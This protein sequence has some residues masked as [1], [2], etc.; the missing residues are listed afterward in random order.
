MNLLKR[1]RIFR[2][3]AGYI[4][5]IRQ[6]RYALNESEET[7][8]RIQKN[9][10]YITGKSKNKFI[11]E[12][13]NNEKNMKE[14]YES[15]IDIKNLEIDKLKKEKIESLNLFISIKEKKIEL[16]QLLPFIEEKLILISGFDQN[17]LQQLNILND[18]IKNFINDFNRLEDNSKKKLDKIK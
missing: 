5:E 12:K 4:H 2:E 7:I 15:I 14:N 1:F 9:Y 10:E 8:K 3:N 17:K 16:E 6:L 11:E 18:R 13:N